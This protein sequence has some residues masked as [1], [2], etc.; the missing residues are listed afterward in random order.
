MARTPDAVLAE[1]LALPAE[2]WALPHEADSDWGRLLTPLA[3]ELARFEGAAEAM[4]PEIDPRQAPNLL[5]DFER[6]LGDDP[7]LGPAAALPND[8]R[9]QL[10]WFRWTQQGGATPAFFV[11]L[12]ATFGVEIE[13]V[14]TVPTTLGLWELGDELV[15]GAEVFTWVVK[16]P[17]T[18][19]T[20]FELGIAELGEPL[21]GFVANPIECVIRR[22]AP[23]HTTVV[24]DYS[25]S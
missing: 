21:G 17:A 6:L 9:R 19:L 1:L 22:H 18:V 24:F 5:A 2:G 23:R 10:A 8:I 14:E 3:G 11:Q 16:L 7:C 25:G 12:A 20:E 13:V 15:S 4:L